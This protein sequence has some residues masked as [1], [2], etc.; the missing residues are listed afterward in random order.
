[1]PWSLELITLL[2]ALSCGSQQ[3]PFLDSRSEICTLE[4]YYQ[5]AFPTAFCPS[6]V[7][8]DSSILF[9]NCSQ[10]SLRIPLGDEVF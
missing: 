1:M 4:D 7:L 5:R 10:I 3:P 9:G 6:F 8:Q 2:I